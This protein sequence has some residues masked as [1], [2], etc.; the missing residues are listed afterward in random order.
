MEMGVDIVIVHHETHLLLERCLAAL[1]AEPWG[2]VRHVVVVDN[3]S[4]GGIA[5]IAAQFPKVQFIANSDNF[6]FAGGCNQGMAQGGAPFCLLLN[7]DTLCTGSAIDRLAQCMVQVPTAGVVAP[8]LVNPDG[9]LQ[10]S[11]RRLPTLAAVLMRGL[12][13]GVGEAGQV[14]RYLMREWDHAQ[15]SEVDWAIGACLMLRRVAV[16]Q[17]GGFDDR[18]F[19]YC[20][21]TDLCLRMRAAAWSVLYDPMAVV[22]HEHRRE[23][24]RIVPGRATRVHLC[25]LLRLF[26]KHRLSAW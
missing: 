25:S 23:S 15:R 21:D 3:A 13:L 2:V 19:L 4:G 17:I 11:C 16:D 8:R 1:C 24:A 7:P 20:E 18:F 5:G 14:G 12:R 9:S 22:I 6:G 10:Y 26:R